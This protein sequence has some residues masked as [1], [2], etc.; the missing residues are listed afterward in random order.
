MDAAPLSPP[1]PGQTPQASRVPGSVSTLGIVAPAPHANSSDRPQLEEEKGPELR[2]KNPQSGHRHSTKTALLDTGSPTCPQQGSGHQ[3]HHFCL[4]SF[5]FLPF[6]LMFFSKCRKAGLKVGILCLVWNLQISHSTFHRWSWVKAFLGGCLKALLVLRDGRGGR[7]G[8]PRPLSDGTY[9][10]VDVKPWVP[11]SHRTSP[12]SSPPSPCSP[13]GPLPPGTHLD[14]VQLLHTGGHPE[15]GGTLAVQTVC[16]TEAGGAV[17]GGAAGQPQA[18]RT[19]AATLTSGALGVPNPPTPPCPALL[20]SWGR[21]GLGPCG[22]PP[23]GPVAPPPTPTKVP[24]VSS[25]SGLSI[26]SMRSLEF[27]LV[28]SL[29]NI[30]SESDRS[31]GEERVGLQHRP[32]RR[33]GLRGTGRPGW[34]VQG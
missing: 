3:P 7:K 6:H 26:L 32:I 16:N 31:S 5:C 14:D 12:T 13:G 25:G 27:H 19:E 17:S 24:C 34:E 30:S 18:H 28:M 23:P 10:S 9:A 11:S 22:H 20:R 33:Q 29:G 21:E 15:L 8:G 1:H 2:A 4:D